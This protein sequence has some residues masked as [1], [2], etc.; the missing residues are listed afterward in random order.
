MNKYLKDINLHDKTVCEVA[1]NL[2]KDGSDSVEIGDR[3]KDRFTIC[4]N[5][6]KHYP[7][8]KIFTYFDDY[9]TE[10]KSPKGIVI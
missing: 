1:L 4:S 10:F 7:D 5:L 3:V 9:K 6:K 2:L 8:R